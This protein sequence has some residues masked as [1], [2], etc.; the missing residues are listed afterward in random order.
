MC[1]GGA[2]LSAAEAAEVGQAAAGG[3][4]EAAA[5]V[6]DELHLLLGG[7][8]VAEIAPGLGEV[9]DGHLV[10]VGREQRGVD[11]GGEPV[12]GAGVVLVLAAGQRAEEFSRRIRRGREAGGLATGGRGDGFPDGVADLCPGCIGEPA[13]VEAEVA[14]QGQARVQA[15][16]QCHAGCQAAPLAESQPPRAA[17]VARVTLSRRTVADRSQHAACG[18]PTQRLPE[19]DRCRTRVRVHGFRPPESVKTSR[20]NAVLLRSADP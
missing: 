8:G 19:R 4:D 20:A 16:D 7:C 17:P 3:G 11:E 9:V 2:E 18:Q 13:E 15:A 1:P 6:G 12:G 14:G 10:Q 5:A